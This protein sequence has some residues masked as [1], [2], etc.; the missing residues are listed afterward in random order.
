ML[1]FCVHF[2]TR[3]TKEIEIYSDIN[4][5]FISDFDLNEINFS[6]SPKFH[7]SKNIG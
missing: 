6:S 7:L 2:V 3:L 1:L 4:F 5:I